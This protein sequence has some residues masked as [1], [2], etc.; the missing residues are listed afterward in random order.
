MHFFQTFV[1]VWQ[2]LK[3]FIWRRRVFSTNFLLCCNLIYKPFECALLILFQNLRQTHVSHNLFSTPFHL[4]WLKVRITNH[5][6]IIHIKFNR[7]RI[8]M[9]STTCAFVDVYQLGPRGSSTM[10]EQSRRNG[11]MRSDTM[12][13]ERKMKNFCIQCSLKKYEIKC[14]EK[15]RNYS[16]WK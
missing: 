13:G 11:R 2:Y 1:N 9:K 3:N 8:A 6:F 16:H 12:E 14:S 15:G 4:N 10:E 7:R 5:L